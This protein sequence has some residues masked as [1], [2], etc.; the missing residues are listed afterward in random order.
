M[1]GRY[2]LI[3][4]FDGSI[5]LQNKI[6]NDISEVNKF[7]NKKN[8][9]RKSE[10]QKIYYFIVTCILDNFTSRNL[11]RIFK[12]LEIIREIDIQLVV[13]TKASEC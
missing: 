5:N 13:S 10:I 11:F 3:F 6:A 7:K 2:P 9:N 4:A 8:R 1:I 12:S